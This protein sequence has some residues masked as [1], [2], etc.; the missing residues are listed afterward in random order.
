MSPDLPILTDIPVGTFAAIRESE[1]AFAAWRAE[2][3]TMSRLLPEAADDPAKFRQEARALFD[4]CAHPTR[5]GNPPDHL[6]FASA[7]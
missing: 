3:R 5:R 4:D 7:A 1:P 6:A 2:L